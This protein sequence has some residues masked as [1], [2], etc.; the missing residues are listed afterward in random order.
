VLTVNGRIGLRRLRW[1]CEEE[2]SE[3]PTDRLLDAAEE[4]ISQGARELACRMNQGATSFV[5]VHGVAED[6]HGATEVMEKD[7]GAE[8]R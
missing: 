6:H 3:A 5:T 8:G 1:H 2:G 4:T 7:R